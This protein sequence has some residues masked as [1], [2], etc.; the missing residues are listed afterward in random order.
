MNS[1]NLRD[2]L[3]KFVRMKNMKELF[4]KAEQLLKSA[5]LAPRVL[6]SFDHGAW[7]YFNYWDGEC[8]I[9]FDE[10]RNSLRLHFFGCD[11]HPEYVRDH[12]YYVT[13]EEELQE[14]A[15]QVVKDNK[16]YEN[17]QR[18]NVLNDL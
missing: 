7:M 9:E 6:H 8:R 4:I 2:F 16:E 11:V 17:L 15:S 12:S 18:K 1:D 14:L 5:G 3:E 10:R 13:N